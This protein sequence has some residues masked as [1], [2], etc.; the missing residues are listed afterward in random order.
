MRPL[1]AVE[2]FALVVLVARSAARSAIIVRTL[3]AD[4]VIE[5]GDWDAL[6]SSA[7]A[8]PGTAQTFVDSFGWV[9]SGVSSRN[10]LEHALGL[11]P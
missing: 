9:D 7:V 2:P 6:N 11:D 8:S 3:G 5:W 10:Q 1:L 4:L